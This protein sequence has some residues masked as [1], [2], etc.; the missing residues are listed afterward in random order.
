[1]TTHK[2]VT[3]IVVAGGSGNRMKAGIKK[4]YLEISGKSVLSITL[5]HIMANRCVDHVILVL[6]EDD[7]AFVENEI[8]PHVKAQKSLVLVSGGEERQD[9]VY[10][11]LKHVVNHDNLVLIHDGVRPFI[12]QTVM[13][14]SIDD[15]R[16]YGASVVAVRVKDTIKQSRSGSM[17]EQTLPRETLWMAQTPQVFRFSLI[18]KA[19]RYARKHELSATDDASLLE[20]INEKAVLTEGSPLNI[21]ITTPEDLVFS[22][23]ILRTFGKGKRI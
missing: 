10:N 8:L 14:R 23:A 19:Y 11:G 1:M 18:M 6:P 13:N 5:E 12:H 15:A 3:A 4:Q 7:I 16:T 22:Q 17:I 20:Y 21:K 9:S 2:D